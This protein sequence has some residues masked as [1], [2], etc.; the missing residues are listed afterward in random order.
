MKASLTFTPIA[1][2]LSVLVASFAAKRVN[3]LVSTKTLRI[4]TYATKS[5]P[6]GR[7][8]NGDDFTA[9]ARRP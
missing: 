8:V 6:R 4:N 2:I 1:R 9:L 7:S 3:V 5:V